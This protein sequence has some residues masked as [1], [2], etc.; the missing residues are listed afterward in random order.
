MGYT[1]FVV[2]EGQRRRVLVTAMAVLGWCLATALPMETGEASLAS[3]SDP[4]PTT[5]CAGGV[6]CPTAATTPVA[7]MS[8]EMHT[9]PELW[10]EPEPPA[11]RRPVPPRRPRK[12]KGIV[13]ADGGGPDTT[14]GEF[15]ALCREKGPLVLIPTASEEADR[16]RERER[17]REPWLRRGL[18]NVVVLHARDREEAQG[19]GFVE[20]LRTA[21]CAW[22]VGGR[23]GRL[24]ERYVG[25]PVEHE[26]HALL[27]RGGVV[28]GSSAGSAILSRVMIHHGNP[29][30]VEGTGFGILPGII[31]DQHFLARQREP[32]LVTMLERHPELVGFGID[33]A[34]ALVIQ[35]DRWRV[36]GRSVVRRCTLQAGCADLPAG[37]SGRLVDPPEPPAPALPPE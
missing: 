31:V 27:R 25:T 1:D 4:P 14:L 17:M 15:A 11:V 33:E 5:S 13:F 36:V 2:L 3:T 12:P 35:G 37:A 7:A 23:Q 32:R 28:G 10:P 20:P 26:L 21:S 16:A 9:V 30:P 22:L 8:P 34:T 19:P 18:Q 29:E 24:E 6:A